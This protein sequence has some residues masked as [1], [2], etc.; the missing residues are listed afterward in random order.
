MYRIL[1]KG[2]GYFLRRGGVALVAGQ[3]GEIAEP[4]EYYALVVRPDALG[5]VVHTLIVGRVVDQVSLIDHGHAV[6]VRRAEPFPAA[7]RPAQV[8]LVI[9][10]GWIPP[11]VP[12]AQRGGHGDEQG[13]SNGVLVRSG[14]AVWYGPGAGAIRLPVVLPPVDSPAPKV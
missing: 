14:P 8:I 9:G 10:A 11:P 1:D 2:I 4:A 6:R 5:I 13:I 7:K 3:L 12:H